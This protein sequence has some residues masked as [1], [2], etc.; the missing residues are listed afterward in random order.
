[1]KRGLLALVA[2]AGMLAGIA[3]AATPADYIAARQKSYKAIGK[4]NKA[5]QDEIRK[6][7][8]S[9]DVIRPNAK[10]LARLSHQVHRWFP[11]GSGPE[12]GVKTAALPAIW[13]Q[14]DQFRLAANRFAGYSRGLNDAAAR[15]DLDKV[16]AYAPAVAGACKACHDSFRARGS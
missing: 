9:L 15:G 13:L 4:A 7:S 11:K 12:A 16:R 6:S 2:S 1:M 3:Y 8:P 14:W 5:V 10:E